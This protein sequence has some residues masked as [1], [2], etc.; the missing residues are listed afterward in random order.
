MIIKMDAN[1]LKNKTVAA[2]D[3]GRKFTGVALFGRHDPYP[4]PY[5]RI[6]Y[7]ND[8]KLAQDIKIIIENENVDVLVVG[9]PF[10][11]DGT[12]TKMTQDVRAFINTI[13]SVLN[14]PI[15]EQDETLSTFEAKD[16][17]EKSPQYNFKVDLQKIDALAASIILEDFLKSSQ[18]S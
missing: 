16:R 17:M 2:I 6:L 1:F 11:T 8:K 7:S 3:Y 12:A 10:L 5:D 4:L 9:V 13:S 18:D 14:I 15:I